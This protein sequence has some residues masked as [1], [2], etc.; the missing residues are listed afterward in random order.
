ME[1]GVAPGGTGLTVLTPEHGY[2]PAGLSHPTAIAID[3]PGNIWVTNA[4]Q[5]SVTLLVGAAAPLQTP[6]EAAFMKKS[7]GQKP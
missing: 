2:K 3:G 4:G 6:V 7:F 1:I 5:P